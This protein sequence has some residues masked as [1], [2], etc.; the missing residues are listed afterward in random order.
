[1]RTGLRPVTCE[2]LKF[3]SLRVRE[4]SLLGLGDV[5]Q[6]GF[7]NVEAFVEL[8]VGRDQRNQD[9]HNIA[10][11]SGS[12]RD[13]AVLVSK[14]GKFLGLC[15]SG[16]TGIAVADEFD[17]THAAKATYLANDRPLLLPLFGTFFETL[18]DGSG[19]REQAILFKG[20]KGRQSRDAGSGVSGKGAAEATGNRRVHDFS[21]TG[22][23]GERQAT[24]EGF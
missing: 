21:A 12:D 23:R 18:A 17:G 8:L 20:F 4:R 7:E 10:I 9:A 3:S 24:T 16:L 2:P 1:M 15:G 11:G 13:E 14:L 22:N 6:A 19:T 5:R